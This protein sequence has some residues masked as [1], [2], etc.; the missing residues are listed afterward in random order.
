[1]ILV[2][3]ATG[4]TG[5]AL[6]KELH[7]Y[8]AGPLRGLTRNATRTSFPGGVEAVQ[9][10][11]AEIASLKPALEGVRSL[12]LVSRIGSDADI[13]ATAQQAGVEHLVQI[14]RA[15]CRER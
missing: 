7:Q 10:D 11:F 2:T 6:L 4:N 5:S 12:F 15:S 9:G 3:G 14:G 8:D 1:M 13:I